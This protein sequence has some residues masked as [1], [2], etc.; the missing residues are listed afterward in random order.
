M[1][2][3]SKK[4][5]AI[6]SVLAM[7]ILFTGAYCN[8]SGSSN[9]SN[10]NSSATPTATNQ[11]TISNMAFNPNSITVTAGTQVT[12]TNQDSVAH[13]VTSDTGAFDSGQLANNGTF[14]FTFATAGTFSYHCSNHPNMT[15]TVTVQ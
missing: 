14:S 9:S 2:K 8:N 3:F 13:T 12:W 15:A 10:S 4:A 11:V 6:G 5:L 7:V 1:T